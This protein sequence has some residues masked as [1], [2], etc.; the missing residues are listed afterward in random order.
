MELLR[1]IGRFILTQLA[2]AGFLL[3]GP[4]IL[5]GVSLFVIAGGAGGNPGF[6]AFFYMAAGPFVSAVWTPFFMSLR[7]VLRMTTFGNRTAYRCGV[8]GHLASC[9]WM[10]YGFFGT[11]VAEVAFVLLFHALS[12]SPLVFFVVA[13][14]VVFSPLVAGLVWHARKRS[15]T[16]GKTAKTVSM[17]SKLRA[18]SLRI[19]CLRGNGKSDEEILGLLDGY[20]H[21]A[22]LFQAS[23]AN[24]DELRACP[25]GSMGELV[26]K[27]NQRYLRETR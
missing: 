18:A 8:R 1:A 7:R 27:R 26:Y 21:E 22:V 12:R 24:T 5:V 4:A 11:L 3:L 15:H 2:I 16:S 6:L 19:A 20:D 17:Q 10:L 9:G 23:L 25:A 14:F 13:P